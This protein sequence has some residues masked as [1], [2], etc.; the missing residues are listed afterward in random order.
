M[1]TGQ[2]LNGLPLSPFYLPLFWFLE[3]PLSIP[4]LCHNHILFSFPWL[5]LYEDIFFFFLSFP[6]FICPTPSSLFLAPLSQ[7]PGNERCYDN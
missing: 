7:V 5:H 2:Q 6:P 1:S 4:L 3:E